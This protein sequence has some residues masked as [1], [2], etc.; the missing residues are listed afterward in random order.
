MLGNTYF[1][2]QVKNKSG[3]LSPDRDGGSGNVNV[4]CLIHTVIVDKLHIVWAQRH[5]DKQYER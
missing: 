3:I 4:Q 1:K 5:P 2:E